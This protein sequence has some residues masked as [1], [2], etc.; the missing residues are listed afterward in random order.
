MSKRS[1]ITNVWLF[2]SGS[3]TFWRLQL[4]R[5]RRLGRIVGGVHCE[6]VD[7]VDQQYQTS[8]YFIDEWMDSFIIN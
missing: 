7:K 3:M 6:L 2:F 1:V 4:Q 8:N 5:L